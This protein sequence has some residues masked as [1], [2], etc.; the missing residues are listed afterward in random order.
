MIETK[1]LTLS[2]LIPF[3][4]VMGAVFGLH[5][6]TILLGPIGISINN[7]KQEARNHD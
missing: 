5:L 3:L 6:A 4:A 7:R 1:I 2:F